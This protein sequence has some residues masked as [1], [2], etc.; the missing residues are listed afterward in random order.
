MNTFCMRGFDDLTKRIVKR[1]LQ[2]YNWMLN[3]TAAAE[4]DFW[5]NHAEAFQYPRLN[6]EGGDKFHTV[7]RKYEVA[8]YKICAY[9]RQ[10]KIEQGLNPDKS[11]DV[12]I[13]A[14]N[15]EYRARWHSKTPGKK[16]KAKAT[17]SPAVMAKKGK[18]L[19]G[20]GVRNPPNRQESLILLGVYPTGKGLI[21][22]DLGKIRIRGLVRDL[23]RGWDPKHIW[24]SETKIK[25]LGRLRIK[26]SCKYPDGHFARGTIIGRSGHFLMHTGFQAVERRQ[27]EVNFEARAIHKHLLSGEINNDNRGAVT[28][29]RGLVNNYVLIFSKSA[30]PLT[31]TNSCRVAVGSRSGA[32]P[33]FFYYYVAIYA[34]SIGCLS[35]SKIQIRRTTQINPS[36]LRYLSNNMEGGTYPHKSVY[37]FQAEFFFPVKPATMLVMVKLDCDIYITAGIGPVDPR[38]RV[39]ILLHN[40]GMY[41]VSEN[42]RTSQKE[43]SGSGNKSHNI[44]GGTYLRRVAGAYQAA[45]L[46]I[47]PFITPVEL[48]FS[49]RTMI[50]NSFRGRFS[51]SNI[52]LN[53][54][55][56][57]LSWGWRKSAKRSGGAYSY[58]GSQVHQVVF[59]P[60][61]KSISTSVVTKIEGDTSRF[62]GIVPG[63]INTTGAYTFFLHRSQP[64][65]AKKRRPSN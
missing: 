1:R 31:A 2:L 40:H 6:I 60:P 61:L 35:L 65:F 50:Q 41:V 7:Y 56:I 27:L 44:L 3:M 47:K 63:N 34:F 33:E 22:I 26:N 10:T 32:V 23:Q 55:Q 18:K 54:T 42:R 4:R 20:K 24:R 16:E 46:P 53:T 49:T 62:S 52:K 30:K 25:T 17:N 57:E 29:H 45:L 13:H 43:R 8:R 37:N 9:T 21:D 64:A 38:I 58:K 14:T 5:M 11:M 19:A 59:P 12:L 48:G 15:T 36:R 28:S 39:N 51:P